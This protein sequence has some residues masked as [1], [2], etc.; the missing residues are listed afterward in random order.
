MLL[1]D[2]GGVDASVKP[3]PKVMVGVVEGAGMSE[4]GK[5]SLCVGCLQRSCDCEDACR[6]VCMK[7]VTV[8]TVRRRLRVSSFNV[9]KKR[10]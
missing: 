8:A 3:S 6:V 9:E 4:E 2:N 1:I 7:K 10:E 5:C